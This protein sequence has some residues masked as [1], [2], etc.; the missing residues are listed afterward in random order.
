VNHLTSKR[1]IVFGAVAV[2]ISVAPAII[3]IWTELEFG[4]LASDPH[5]VRPVPTL[6]EQF[7]LGFPA[8]TFFVTFM[9]VGVLMLLAGYIG[10]RRRKSK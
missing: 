9:M 6:F 4:N 2:L 3:K 10:R 1:F 5:W 8:R 7:I